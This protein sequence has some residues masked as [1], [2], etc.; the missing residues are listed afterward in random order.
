MSVSEVDARQLLLQFIPN[1]IGLK[2]Q[3]C[4]IKYIRATEVFKLLS[5]ELNYAK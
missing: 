2:L 4:N 3:Q 1:I 5:V